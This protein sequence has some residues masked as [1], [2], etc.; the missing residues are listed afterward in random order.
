VPALLLTTCLAFA[1]KPDIRADASGDP[2]AVSSEDGKYADKD[3]NPTFNIKPDGTTDYYTFSGYIRYTANCMPCHG[4]DGLGS[5]YGPVLVDSLQNLTY[6]DVLTTIASGK[7]DVSSAQTLVMPTFGDNRNVMCYVDAIYIYLRAR[8][9]HALDRGRP[10]AHDP[11][12]AAF[13]KAED[14]CMK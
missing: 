8:S 12:P 10:L 3:G 7:K 13:T 1:Q 4:P 9:D 6:T 2:T 14:E 11:K 5:S